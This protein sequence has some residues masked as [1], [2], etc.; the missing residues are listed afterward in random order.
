MIGWGR[1]EAKERKG[2]EAVR[3][4][5]PRHVVDSEYPLK[6]NE[7]AGTKERLRNVSFAGGEVWRRHECMPADGS[8]YS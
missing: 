1:E 6:K 2:E 5:G 7:Q 8:I 4:G 3:G